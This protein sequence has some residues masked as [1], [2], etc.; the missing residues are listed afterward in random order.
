MVIVA[1]FSMVDMRRVCTLFF[2]I[3]TGIRVII[4][5][6]KEQLSSVGVGNMFR[7]IIESDILTVTVSFQT[8]RTKV[9]EPNDE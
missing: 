3:Q 5:G 7:E 6:D 9:Y 8:G 1:E 4:V 2:R